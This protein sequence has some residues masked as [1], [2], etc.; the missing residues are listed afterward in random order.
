MNICIPFVDGA[1]EPYCADSLSSKTAL[2]SVG[3]TSSNPI[4][5]VVD[6]ARWSGSGWMG[7]W[8]IGMGGEKSKNGTSVGDDGIFYNY[9]HDWCASAD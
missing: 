1:V 2:S 8:L 9:S 6:D 5:E 7:V 3:P 4:M